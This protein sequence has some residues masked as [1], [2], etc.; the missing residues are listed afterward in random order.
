[1]FNPATKDDLA[2][3]LKNS[4]HELKGDLQHAA[5]Q[6]GR[7][8]RGLVNSA[9]NEIAHASDRVTSEIRSNPVRSAA[10]ALGA[11]V[12]LGAILRR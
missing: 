8:V 9:G 12:L 11:G 1:M 4:V 2:T 5:N 3:N 10:I 7:D 6:A